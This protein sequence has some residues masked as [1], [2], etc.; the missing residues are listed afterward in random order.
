MPKPNRNAF[1]YMLYVLQYAQDKLQAKGVT[2]EYLAEQFDFYQ[3]TSAS[4][5]DQN[6]VCEDAKNN[7]D[8]KS[9]FSGYKNYVDCLVY[10]LQTYDYTHY[11]NL[12][13]IAELKNREARIR[14]LPV[15]KTK[16]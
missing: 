5:N 14:R 6:D 12:A 10:L 4:L 1:F 13:E 16:K 11:E 2:C 8:K 3:T 9:T 15:K 7:V